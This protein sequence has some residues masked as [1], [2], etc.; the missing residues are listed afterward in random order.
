MITSTRFAQELARL[1]PRGVPPSV[2]ALSGGVD[3]MCMAFLLAQHKRLHQPDMVLRAVTVD[4]AV[5]E[6][7]D[8]EAAAVGRTVAK[9]GLPH[10]VRRLSYELA[11]SNFEEVARTKRYAALAAACAEGNAAN[12]FVAHTLNDQLETHLFRLKG[13]S[14]ILGLRGIRAVS[15]APL[16]PTGPADVPMQLARPLLGF[17][18]RQIIDTCRHHGVEWFEDPTNADIALTARNRLRYLVD[19]YVP[20]HVQSDPSLAVL[21]VALLTATHR[22]VCRLDRFYNNEAWHLQQRLLAADALHLDRQR[23][24]LKFAIPYAEFDAASPVVLSRLLY[25]NIHPV[26]ASLHYFWGYAKIERALVPRLVAAYRQ[27]A[28]SPNVTSVYKLSYFNIL[29]KVTF[30]DILQSVVLDLSRPPFSRDSGAVP[31]QPQQWH[32]WDERFWLR[33]T[34]AAA[35]V[36]PFNHRRHNALLERAGI[37]VKPLRLQQDPI[38]LAPGGFALP[39]RGVYAGVTVEC[40][41]KQNL[42]PLM[43]EL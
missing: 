17:C 11:P 14:T 21:T 12:V 18:K 30:D 31:L 7:S 8:A 25:G 16:A 39:T 24:T 28:L 42:Y 19:H 33:T 2:V 6:G 34:A 5:R 43:E 13:D 20:E 38:V 40:S 37:A 26:A 9:W 22:R 4:H 36:E 32:L 41:L 35:T 23:A 3:S 10:L 15:R 29:F 27:H 1:F